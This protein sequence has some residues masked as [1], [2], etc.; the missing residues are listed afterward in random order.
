MKLKF[1]GAAGSVTGSQSLLSHYGASFLVDCGLYQGAKEDRLRNWQEPQDLKEVRAILLTHA[2]IDHSGLLPR[3]VAKGWRG[4]IYC[5]PA[6]K[7]LL[8]IMLKDAARLQEED[9]KF[10][11]KTKYS[12]HQPAL[13]LYT[14]A[15]AE[16]TIEMLYAIPFGVRHHLS[17]EISF[18]F[19]RAGHILGSATLQVIYQDQDQTRQL[20][21]SGDRGG[22]HSDI[23]RDPQQIPVTDDLV[24]ESTYGDRQ[25]PFLGRLDRLAEVINKVIGR[26]GTLVIPS[27]AVGRSQDLLFSIYCLMNEGRV[28][29]IP[30][31]LDSPM[32]SAVTEVYRENADE[33]KTIGN[34]HEILR[35]LSTDFY[36]TVEDSDESMLLCLNENPKIVLSASGMLQGG[37]VLHHLKC[38]L[39]NEKNGVLFVGFQGA[40]TKGRVLQQ[41]VTSLRIHHQ[42][43]SVEAEIFT[44]DGYSAHADAED[45]VASLRDMTQKPKRIFLNHGEPQGQKVLA[46]RIQNDLKVPVEVPSL[47]AEYTL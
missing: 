42:E 22:G 19:S 4:P 34:D 21:F 11:N 9:A 6:T 23:L 44:I 14:V 27:F 10:A 7:D 46:E 36:K 39:P 28:P 5:T 8:V 37:R 43:V 16:R 2:H 40:G 33:L 47:G 32:A 13:P 18:E 17:P 26:G 29:R 35:A 45:L 25:I 20:T 41:G 31:Y 12:Y 3:W 38:K 30:L 24:L 15:D 1:Q